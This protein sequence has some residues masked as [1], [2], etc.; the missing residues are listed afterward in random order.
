MVDVTQM[1]DW[2]W[3]LADPGDALP[4]RVLIADDDELVGML[5]ARLLTAEGHE[6][7]HVRNGRE[8]LE[9]LARSNWDM[10]F[11]DLE[12]PEVDGIGLLK[13]IAHHGYDVVPIV[14][15][16][17]A[18][19]RDVMQTARLG[20]F[21]FLLKPMRPSMIRGVT[22]R[23]IE[24]RRAVRRS[25]ILARLVE[26]WESIFNAWPDIV[27]VL[28]PSS[29]ILQ[30]NRAICRQL[31]VS[32]EQIRGQDA[33]ELLCNGAHPPE[34]CIFRSSSVSG[35][36]EPFEFQRP[37]WGLEFLMTPV[38]LLDR[39]E[40][41][42]GTLF[43][44]RNITLEKR[45]E[46]LRRDYQR[47]LQLLGSDRM[48]REERER[49]RLASLL[50]D[51]IGQTLALTSIKLSH[52]VKTVPPAC[53]ED[54]AA[55][56]DLLNEALAA[57]RSLTFEIS[58]PIL[59]ELGL[60][61]AISA[62]LEQFEKRHGI[63]VALHV[64][65]PIPDLPHDLLGS[66]YIYTRELI[67]NCIKHAEA[68]EVAVTILAQPGALTLSVADDGKGFTQDA[69]DPGSRVPGGYGL[70]N[71]RETLSLIG[72]SVEISTSPKG[73]GCVVLNMPLATAEE[74]AP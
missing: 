6:C 17:G 22:Q 29:R 33:H 46:N 18:D 23:V 45:A 16:G 31:E 21:D 15:T 63:G 58:P 53:R 10:I 26:H 36:A 60:E 44:G 69:F 25:R 66:L 11:V 41:P 34:E 4:T 51:S 12:M 52:L 14:I 72:G 24:H 2:T 7:L 32:S 37:D 1:P 8:A 42:W 49:R 54:L 40:Q 13:E 55:A 3:Q 71:I 62:L 64:P 5:L 48:V 65:N 27:I 70:F 20:S 59:Y 73:G 56:L 74:P 19:L 35:P 67:V 30:A 9:E 43:I 38:A 47:Q 68:T 57:T 50:H 61:P 39:D 28:D